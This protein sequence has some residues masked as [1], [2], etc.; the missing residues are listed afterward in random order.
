MVTNI[1]LTRGMNELSSAIQQFEHIQEQIKTL[2]QITEQNASST[3]AILH[4]V[5]DENKMLEMMT[6]TTDHIQALS[7]ILKSL[8]TNNTLESTK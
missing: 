3:E 6:T 7:V 5:E 4:S 8:V 2:N 1:D